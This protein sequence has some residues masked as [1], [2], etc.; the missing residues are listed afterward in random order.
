M[1]SWEQTLGRRVAVTG[2]AGLR[3]VRLME[4]RTVCRIHVGCPKR[5][6]WPRPRRGARGCRASSVSTGTAIGNGSPVSTARPR[7]STSTS[8]AQTLPSVAT[9]LARPHRSQPVARIAIARGPRSRRRPAPPAAPVVIRR[10]GRA[11]ASGAGRGAPPATRR[12]GGS[13]ASLA[14]RAAAPAPLR[15]CS[16]S[17]RTAGPSGTACTTVRAPRRSR[18]EPG[19]SL[20]ARALVAPDRHRGPRRRGHVAELADRTSRR[21]RCPRTARSGSRSAS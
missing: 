11:G 5:A 19:R 12:S 13:P 6:P 2:T 15:L 1:Q 14:R 7:W 8:S 18:V 20:A 9:S 4:R 21:G 17:P 10:R 16:A 3:V